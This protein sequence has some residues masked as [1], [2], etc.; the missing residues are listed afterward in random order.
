MPTTPTFKEDHS[1][2]LPAML[3]LANLGWQYL[4]PAQV[5]QLREGDDR[6]VLLKPLLRKWLIENNTFSF[7]GSQHSF[8]AAN[9]DIAIEQLEKISFADGVQHANEEAYDKLTLGTSLEERIE[10]DRKSFNLHYI[11][12][13]HPGNNIY[14][15]TAEMPVLRSGKSDTY[16][17]DIVCFVNGIPLMV[18]ESKRPD[19]KTKQG[20]PVDQAI[21]QFIRNE[22]L[23]DGIPQ[24]FLYTQLNFAIDGSTGK[25][26]TSG[27]AKQF[28]SVWKEKYSSDQQSL[29]DEQR[30]LQLKNKVDT[31]VWDSIFVDDFAAARPYFA[32]L[33]QASVSIN[34]QDRLLYNLARPDRLIE[35]GFRYILYDAHIKKVARYQQYFAVQRTL[36]RV[37]DREEGKRKGGVVWHTQGSGKSLTMVM[38]AKALALEPAI[39]NPKIIIVTDRIDLD[40]QI[41]KTFK[42]CGKEAKQARSGR[43]LLK[44]LQD[45]KV[46]VITT[47]LDKFYRPQ[48][49]DFVE[50]SPDVFVLIDESHRSQYGEANVR[51]QQVLPNACYIGFTGTPLMKKEK[52][53]AN[54]FGGYIDKYTIDQAVDDGAVVPLLYEGREI[55]LTLNKQALDNYFELISQSLTENQRSELK[56]HY[57]K[58]THLSEADQRLYMIAQDVSRHYAATWQQTRFK[59]QL[60]APSKR[61]A[62][63]LHKYFQEIGMV[64]TEVVISPPDTREGYD[65]QQEDSDDLTMQ[66][67]N[68]MM[69]T[70][71]NATRYQESIIN[72]FKE[73]DYPEII[74]VVDKLLTG[75]DAPNNIVLYVCRSLREHTLLQA[76]ARVNRVAA[77]KD[78]GY[79]LD[80]NVE[81]ILG[82]LDE[83]LTNYS[84]LEGF[85][86]E[87]LTG[88]VTSVQEELDKIDQVH[89]DLWGVFKTV[90]NKMDLEALASHLGDED[91]RDEFYKLHSQFARLMKMALG[92]LQWIKD[93]PI[94]KQDTYR[95]DLKFF[96]DLRT[97]VKRRYSDSINYGDYAPQIQ[98]LF[99]QHVTAG[100]ADIRVELVDI[101]DKEAFEAEV[102]KMVGPR[103][104]ADMIA[105][106]TSVHI[107]ENIEKDPAFYKRMS[108][109]LQDLVD[110][111][112]A[113]WDNASQAARE[114]FV[115]RL[116]EIK[117]QTLAQK[118]SSIPGDLI[119]EPLTK[120]IYHL[121][122]QQAETYREDQAADGVSTQLISTIANELYQ[123]IMRNK[124]V[125]FKKRVDVQAQMMREMDDIL[126]EHRTSYGMPTI[127]EK[128]VIE[129]AVELAKQNL[130]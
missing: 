35:I 99:D 94:G 11:D 112:H 86:E 88:T 84:S 20:T 22:R 124:K 10:G 49:E 61:A 6:Q 53:T 92:T 121:L 26:G 113:K 117:D 73:A 39:P 66:F 38:L 115:D 9:I 106:R 7:K 33:Y 130:N 103:A 91:R 56:K 116:K 60:T 85:E 29:Q 47:I 8:S 48:E 17:P 67:W 83:A 45:P 19:L 105:S 36:S 122:I 74:I 65:S 31:S 81:P 127:N 37:R 12:W 52:S 32:S 95:R 104:K 129:Q 3:L 87:D 128:E 18:I 46:D 2:Q 68:S 108:Q 27:T 42:A 75:F 55:P 98:R 76:I 118:E 97:T 30:L 41:T 78:Y 58:A 89:A 63:K 123:A 51:M 100:S 107:S 79:I 125:D 126:Y 101:S 111:M 4:S 34:D 96:T 120:A 102:E 5:H 110:E 15:F 77:G 13:Q 71:G 43:H 24:L 40:D 64:T 93:T 69:N 70:Y 1:S 28:W 80:Y 59:G 57:S 72:R 16:R 109:L 119:D 62:I 82:E 14:H 44:L 50:Q 54:K 90:S 21:G 25:Y 114:A 23:E